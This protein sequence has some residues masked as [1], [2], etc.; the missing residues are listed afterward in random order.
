MCSI[1]NKILTEAPAK[2]LSTQFV[3]TTRKSTNYTFGGPI[4]VGS[5]NMPPERK[6]TIPLLGKAVI[7]SLE[8]IHQEGVVKSILWVWTYFGGRGEQRKKVEYDRTEKYQNA[9]QAARYGS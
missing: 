7:F 2:R 5:A 3:T 8:W 6:S 9:L 1:K 4:S